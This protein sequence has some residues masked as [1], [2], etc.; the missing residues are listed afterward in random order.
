MADAEAV[1][2][3]Y[4][5]DAEVGYYLAWPIHRSIDDSRQFMAFSELEWQEKPGGPY[6]IW[7][8]TGSTLIGSTGFAFESN[9]LASTGYVIAKRYWGQGFAT[10]A[11]LG[12]TEVA[13]RIKRRQALR[14]VPPGS[15]RIAKRAWEVRFPERGRHTGAV[16]PFPTRTT[17]GC[18]QCCALPGPDPG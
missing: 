15:R 13:A 16:Q 5:S 14:L 8:D 9:D 3:R 4:A 6:L 12:V 1:F 11:L 18:S 10:E 17:T 2:S 7:D